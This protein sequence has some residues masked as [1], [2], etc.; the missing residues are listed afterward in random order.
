MTLSQGRATI[1]PEGYF[2]ADAYVAQANNIQ[3]YTAAELGITDR[4]AHETIRV[5]RDE[6]DVFAQASL[7]TATRLPITLDHP[8]VMVDAR[9][10]RDFAKGETGEE[11]MRDGERMRVPIRVTDEAA[12]AS[13]QTD[14]QEFS[15]GYTAEIVMDAGE[16][17]GEAYDAKA[18]EIRYNHLAACRTARG[19]P[20]LRITDQRPPQN[21]AKTMPKIVM[22]DG[23]PVD[24][25]NPD[26]AEMT[27]NHLITARDTAQAALE[28]AVETVTARDA[29]I[30]ERDATIV[31]L[32]DQAK[33][34]TPAALRDASQ[35]YTRTR[36]QGELLGATVTDEMDVPA[37]H[38]AAV[39]VKLGDAAKDYTP[40][41]NVI[42]FDTLAAQLGDDDTNDANVI[43]ANVD[44]LRANIADGGGKP[45]TDA[46]QALA[47]A[48]AKRLDR[49]N[50]AHRNRGAS[51]A[52]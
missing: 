1:T 9:N 52:Q 39:A 46:K 50:N 11:I 47:D 8:S 25:A 23:A 33:P 17:K 2:V 28:S 16:Y 35:G 37:I 4:A 15:L 21:G 38:A 30:V 48:K 32:T 5:F 42:A 3:E 26:A 10:W 6:A 34:L 22:V 13:V 43:D 20:E 27:V 18:T 41:Q 36:R 51:A 7:E 40:E 14:R 45:V 24:V 12:V 31:T 49:L 19:G 44:P 29:T